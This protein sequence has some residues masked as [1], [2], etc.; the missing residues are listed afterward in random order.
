MR[1]VD[2]IKDL[3]HELGRYRKKVADQDAQ[4]EK[5]KDMVQYNMEGAQELSRLIDAILS[6]VASKYGFVVRDENQEV[7][8]YRLELDDFAVDRM[9][10][11]FQVNSQKRGTQYIIGAMLKEENDNDRSD[12]TEA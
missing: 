1:N 10:D 3:E 2:K 12:E 5:L 8:G 6:A 11:R 7:I 4:I 9:M